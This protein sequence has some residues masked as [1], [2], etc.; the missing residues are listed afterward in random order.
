MRFT[1]GSKVLKADYPGKR[2]L[3]K[4]GCGQEK[5][6]WSS[7]P[8][9]MSKASAITNDFS[10]R[11]SSGIAS[12]G[13]GKISINLQYSMTVG[14]SRRFLL[15]VFASIP[16]KLGGISVTSVDSR[17]LLSYQLIRSCSEFS[18]LPL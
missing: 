10:S 16:S 13:I 4:A 18:L 17:Q 5:Y 8:G 15:T 14:F 6:A 7:V 3:C 12:N 9:M 11:T 1:A 2:H